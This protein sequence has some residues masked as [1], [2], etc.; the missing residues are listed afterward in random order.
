MRPDAVT[1]RSPAELAAAGLIDAAA[2][3]A[4]VPVAARYAVALP[5][6]IVALIDPSDPEDPIARQFVPSAAELDHRPEDLVDPIG[7]AVHSPV[8]GIVHRYPDRVLLTLLH[9]CPVY[10]RFCFRRERVGPGVDAVLPAD[11]VDA[12][13]DYVAA[14]PAIWEVILT[15]GDPLA[16]SPRRIASVMARLAAIDHVKIVRFHTRVPVVT[17]EAVTPELVAALGAS[18]K[19][20]YVG[21]HCNHPREL[22]A[23]A[24]AACAR[25]I[26]AGLALVS[27][28]VLL[29]G[30]NDDAATLAELMRSLVELRIRPYYL[31][32]GD[33]APGT[34]HLRVPLEE[35]RALVRALRGRVSGLCQPTYVLDIPGGHGKVPVG[36]DY[37]SDGIVTDPWGGQHSY[38]G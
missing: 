18:G 29:R 19:T 28:T 36:P 11:A 37:L 21:L 14:H 12:A 13:L 24:R 17:P 15:G 23:A 27:Q 22:T 7:D 5:P 38:V 30:V 31:H 8:P 6:A 16:L 3:A 2:V 33:L 9:V 32:H 4:L 1:L 25:L 10:C 35:G 20:T 34:A 26:D